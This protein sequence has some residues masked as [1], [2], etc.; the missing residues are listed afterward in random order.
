MPAAARLRA[1]RLE[2]GYSLE[3][4]AIATGLT[5]AEIA[6]AEETNGSETPA[7]H[8]DRLEHVLN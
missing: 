6:A 2:K 1:A 5:V 3:D 4:L 8:L 7:H